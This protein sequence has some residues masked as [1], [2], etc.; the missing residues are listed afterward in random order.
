MS[1]CTGVGVASSMGFGLAGKASV[2]LAGKA[3]VG[4]LPMLME[5]ST[6]L[7]VGRRRALLHNHLASPPG[8]TT[9]ARLGVDERL[10]A[11]TRGDLGTP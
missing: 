3:S 6:T 8:C 4:L 7:R 5:G 9:S 2:G 1:G 10:A 11:W